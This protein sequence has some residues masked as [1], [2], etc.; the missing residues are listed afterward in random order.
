MHVVNYSGYGTLCSLLCDSL[1]VTFCLVI[2][3]IYC[4]QSL[5]DPIFYIGTYIRL[6]QRA[7]TVIEGVDATVRICAEVYNPTP[8]QSSC[9][10]VFYFEIYL[11]VDGGKLFV[12]TLSFI[13][14]SISQS[15]RTFQWHLGHVLS[16]HVCPL[17]LTMMNNLS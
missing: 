9:P 1:F 4:S 3:N 15:Q 5:C 13:E 7:F 12:I 8:D 17:Q 10:V 14:R 16:T 6:E 2:L 11:S